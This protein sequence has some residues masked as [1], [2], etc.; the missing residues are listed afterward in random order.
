MSNSSN[1]PQD[2][3]PRARNLFQRLR[4]ILLSRTS[5]TIGTILLLGAIAGG[6]GLWIFIQRQLAPLVEESLRKSINRPVE[7]GKL[8]SFSWTGAARFGRSEIP[9]TPTDTDRLTVEAIEV[10]VNPW[11]LLFNNTLQ[12]DLTLIQPDVYL[13]QDPN[14]VWAA[15]KIKTGSGGGGLKTEIESLRVVRG[16]LILVPLPDPG[17]PKGAIALQQ[18]NGISHFLEENK[19]IKFDLQALPVTGGNIRLVGDTRPT[20]EQYNLLVAGKT[21]LAD[22][23]S[24]LL[25]LKGLK[26]PAGRFDGNLEVKI[27]GDLPVLAWGNV[28]VDKA[29]FKIAKVPQLFSNSTGDIRFRSTEIEIQNVSTIYGEIPGRVTGTLDPKAGFNITGFTY[30]VPLKPG[31][32]TLKLKLPVSADA[33]FRSNL[34]LVGAW[35]KPTLSGS[36]F[37]TDLARIDKLNFNSIRAN[38][39]L[40]ASQLSITGIEANPAVGG[41]I[42]GAGQIN[43]EKTGKTFFNLQGENIPGD[44]IAKTYRTNLPITLGKISGRTQ[45]FGT[46]GNL[47]TLVQFDAPQATYPAKGNLLITP[48][49]NIFFPYATFQ[50]GQGKIETKGRLIE[51]NWQAAVQAINVNGN[52]LANLFNGKVPSVFQGLIAGNFL[53]TGNLSQAQKFTALGSG[54]IQYDQGSIAGTNVRVNSDRWQGNFVASNLPIPRLSPETPVNLKPGNITGRFNLSG[55]LQGFKPE[56]LQG[57]GVGTVVFP[58]GVVTTNNLQLNNGRWQGNLIANSLAITR[59]SPLV[60]PNLKP[61]KITGVFNASGIL[62]K[63]RP[64]N[65]QGQGSGSLALPDGIVKAVFVE[66]NNGD[67][68]GNFSTDSLAVTR[69]VPEIPV[70][71]RSGKIAGNFALR[72]NVARI[73]PDTIIGGGSGIFTLPDG[74]I[75]ATNLQL[76]NGDW[77]GNFTTSNLAVSRVVPDIPVNLKSGKVTGGFDLRGNLAKVRPD[78]VIGTGSGIFTLPD[79]VIKAT[80]LQLNNGDWRGNFTTNNLTASRVVPDIPVTLRSGKI[81]GSFDLAGNLAKVRPDTVRGVGSGTFTLPN[82][83][84]KAANVRL[85]YGNFLAN[86]TTNNLAIGQLSPEIPTNLKPGKLT[87]NFRVAGN[88]ANLKPESINASGAGTL[89]LPSGAIAANSFKLT[90]GNFLA[91]LTTNDLAI[92]Q[93]SPDI[94]PNLKPGKLT[95]NFTVAGNLANLKPESIN[96]SGSGT[97]QLPSAAIAANSFKLTNGNFLANLTTNDLAIGQLSPDI[98]PNLKPGKLTGNFTVAGNLANLKPESI[99]GSGSGSLILPNGRVTGSN[100]QLAQG[101]WQGN[102]ETDNLLL[103]QVAPQVPDNIKDGKLTANFFLSGDLARLSPDQINGNGSGKLILPQGTVNASNVEINQGKWQGNFQTDNLGIASLVPQV[104]DNLPDGKLTANFNLSG[105]LA[106]PTLASLEGNGAGKLTWKDGNLTAENVLLNNGRWQG[107]FNTTNLDVGAIAQFAPTPNGQ[108]LEVTGKLNA[109]LNASGSLASFNPGNLQATGTIKLVDFVAYGRKFEP[110]LAGNLNVTPEQGV[111]LDLTGTQ[112]RIA[113]VLSPS[114]QPVSFYLR[115]GDLVAS[116]KTAGDNFLIDTQNLPLALV[117]DIAPIPANFAS[118]PISGSLSG[119]FI[120]NLKNQSIQANNAV[121]DKP[122]FGRF[123]GDKLTA[124]FT[125]ANGKATISNTELQQGNNRYILN[126]NITPTARGPQFQAKLQIPQGDVQD[127]LTS[128]QIFELQDFGR[129]FEGREFGNA[130]DVPAVFSGISSQSLL[131][132][133]NRLTEIKIL[134]ARQETQRREALIP[135]LRDLKGKF[136]GEINA[137]GSLSTGINADF[138]LEGKDWLW[139]RYQAEQIIAKGTFENGILTLLPLR[140][141]SQESLFS[142]TGTLGGEQQAG[143]V[144][145][146]NVPAELVQSIFKLP[147]DISGNLNATATLSGSTE[148]PS[149][150]GEISLVQGKINQTPIQSVQSSFDY[151]DSTLNFSTNGII[152]GSDP[153]QI[154]GSV[155]YKLPFS[156]QAPTSDRLAINVSAQ[157]QALG[158]ISLLSRNQITWVDGKGQIDLKIE[159]Q[160][161]PNTGK[162]LELVAAGVATV[163][164]ATIESSSLQGEP[165]TQVKGKVFFDFDHIDVESLQGKFSQG[166]VNAVGTL[167]ISKPSLTENPLTINLDQIAINIKDRYTGGVQG[168]LIVNRTLFNPEISGEIELFNGQVL[169]TDQ[170]ETVTQVLDNN[171]KSLPVPKRQLLAQ[172]ATN[173]QKSNISF[174]N[175]KLRL[176]DKV[177]ITKEPILNFLASG[178]LNINGTLDAPLP[179]GTVE[180]ERGQVNLFTTQFRLARGYQQTAIFTPRQGL[181]PTLDVRLIAIVPETTRSRIPIEPLSAEISDIPSTNLGAVRTVRIEAKVTGRA[182]DLADTLSLNSNPPRSRTEIVALLGGGFVDTLG[183]GETT[184]GL[185][186][187]AGSALL[188]NVQNAIGDTLGLSEFR[189]F[190]TVIS[191]QKRGNLTLGLG[192]EAGID[193]NPKF[194]LSVL[195]ILNADQPPQ[196]G[197]RYRLND[198]V[199][200]RGSTD[201]SGET[202]AVVEYES[203]F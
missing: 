43:L 142:L 144:K 173:Q 113:L 121:V 198:E 54:N 196:Y 122:V 139:Q 49:G 192:A 97:L 138:N 130:S 102:F 91:N 132:Q 48:G 56:S 34:R 131:T 108:P 44:I 185:A 94:P 193:I 195:A 186:N 99:N 179:E 145:I 72:G 62:A 188:G 66:L 103:G 51:K 200:F 181:I 41:K 100:L 116:G 86:L 105:N 104:A 53:V 174:N 21:L 129:Q 203:R 2:R 33:E 168:K 98:P 140:I 73:R 177:Q 81:A 170:T 39:Q 111:N 136:S 18:V 191:N 6:I 190:P 16:Q 171:S 165:L 159:G 157:N 137:A 63:I 160:I 29:T 46:P 20:K 60:P 147:I 112:D 70:N 40:V 119:N 114:Y 184:L 84:I 189:L 90:N 79:G 109:N 28:R 68:R 57:N 124:N 71:L 92:G 4:M 133:I 167:A 163:D 10:S 85:N 158:L 78:T 26:F 156:T 47:Q 194:S 127:V 151:S 176:G 65:I 146:E 141:Q 161:E 87:S 120:I 93:L 143:Q 118:Q 55:D 77:R 19:R 82:G 202:R 15:T 201:F 96:A 76:N 67:W 9:P 126:A 197:I 12:L 64:D 1:A 187:L 110:L 42:S 69:I 37:T 17:Q 23:M 89:Q 106:T 25:R 35:E 182:D 183:R 178:N 36:V 22:D 88:L 150:R 117:K 162:I 125:Y 52:Q 164:N 31:L 128:F 199:L 101:R 11:R 50:V 8:E 74:V 24:R 166:Q 7:V 155:P 152:S 175:L 30:P 75:K 153:I 180:L 27:D 80:N 83:E 135:D 5:I 58:D 115:Q 149:S 123:R 169:L 61:G 13:E 14:R 59:I 172:E 107:N 3:E 45:V 95:S 148:N 154:I 32:R 38:F 134:Q